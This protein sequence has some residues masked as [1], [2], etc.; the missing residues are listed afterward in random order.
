LQ[1]G[2]NFKSDTLKKRLL[3]AGLKEYKCENPECG[4]TS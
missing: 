3:E 4:I 2:T 1:K